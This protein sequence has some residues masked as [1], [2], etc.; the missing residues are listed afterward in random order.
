M[1]TRELTPEYKAAYEALQVARENYEQRRIS[2]AELKEAEN[3]FRQIRQVL[4]E[5]ALEMA[6]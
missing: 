5:E 4:M 6:Q 1:T 2:E 3:A